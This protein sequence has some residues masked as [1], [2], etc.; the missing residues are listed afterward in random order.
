MASE[1]NA[2]YTIK[3]M[4]S[5]LQMAVSAG[6]RDNG[7][8]VIQWPSDA[9]DAQVFLVAGSDADMRILTCTTLLALAVAGGSVEPGATIIQWTTNSSINQRFLLFPAES[10]DTAADAANYLLIQSEASRLVLA[11]AGGST[12]RGTNVIQWT[13]LGTPDQMFS[14]EDAGDGF[15][16]F[17]NRKSGMM[18]AIRSGSTKRGAEL[19]QWPA[20]GSDS[21]RFLLAGDGDHGYMIL[22]K[23]SIKLLGIQGGSVEEGAGVVQ[24]FASGAADQWFALEDADSGSAKIKSQPTGMVLGILGGSDKPKARVVQWQDVNADDQRFALRPV[25]RDI[26]QLD[27]QELSPGSPA[28]QALLR[29]APELRMHPLELYFPVSIQDYVTGSQVRDFFNKRVLDN[30]TTAQLEQFGE[31][32][33]RPNHSDKEF[34][35]MSLPGDWDDPHR[36]GVTPVDRKPITTGQYKGGWEGGRIEAPMA[37]RGFTVNGAYWFDYVFFYPYNGPQIMQVRY[38]S[39]PPG[40]HEYGYTAVRPLATHIGDFEH[41]QVLVDGDLNTPLAVRVFGHGDPAMV[42]RGTPEWDRLGWADPE[43]KHVVL[44]S[45]LHS[46]ATYT[47]KGKHEGGTGVPDAKT[48]DWCDDVGAIWQGWLH[49]TTF[50]VTPAGQA[51]PGFDEGQWP[52]FYPHRWGRSRMFKSRGEISVDKVGENVHYPPAVVR[53]ILKDGIWAGMQAGTLFPQLVDGLGVSPPDWWRNGY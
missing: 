31:W 50:G 9:S 40:R 15:V 48:V 37:S 41:A 26:H 11:I 34:Y 33:D 42:T 17:R 5:G 53:E 25:S 46:H 27:A 35:F 51:L 2:F 16:S 30:P 38:P 24:W 19:I 29:F 21:Q 7:A 1:L 10:E 28:Y 39:W 14:Q 32:G 52:D 3:D 18:L 47:S 6:S 23:A 13:A 36:F 20:D 4:G 8:P 22:P 43:K 49:L 45:G 44:Y 12:E